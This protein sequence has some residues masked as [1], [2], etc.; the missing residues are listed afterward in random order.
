MPIEFPMRGENKDLTPTVRAQL[1]GAFIQLPDGVTHYELGGPEGAPVVVLVHG[2]SV[3]YFIWDPT[4]E[5]LTAAGFRVLRYDLYGRGFSDRPHGEY[6][7]ALFDRQL[8]NLLDLLGIRQVLGLVGLSM[9]GIISANFANLHP[10]MLKKLILIDPAGFA[11]EIPFMMKLLTAPGLGELFFS[12]AGKARMKALFSHD[13]FD[14][15]LIE[16]FIEEYTP[17]MKY[18]GF[19]RAI[20]ST[21]RSGLLESG[22]EVYSRL[23]QHKDLPV[24]LF[25]GEQDETVP[26]RYSQILLEAVP[27]AVFHSIANA[28]HIPHYE[29]TEEVNPILLEFLNE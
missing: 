11:L 2:F 25:W 19:K 12:V 15:K 18:K 5:V 27:H 17:A 9:G 7:L 14:P 13:I 10:E 21:V 23:G 8:V 24:L 22:E 4:Y 6:D 16:K 20:L 26:F 1:P 28:G 3:P 29:K